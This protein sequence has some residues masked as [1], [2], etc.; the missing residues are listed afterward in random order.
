M[1]LSEWLASISTNEWT[2]FIKRLSANDTGATKSHQVGVYI[3]E[4]V[5]RAVF[6]KLNNTAERN[7][8]HIFISKVES[9]DCKEQEL[10]AIYYNN[11]FFDGTRNEKRIT[12]WNTDTDYN[13]VQD[14]ESTGSLTIFAFHRHEGHNSNYLKVWV[15]R[16][17]TEEDETESQIG[18]ILP[19]T[20]MLNSGDT[21]FSNYQALRAGDYLY[22]IPDEWKT[23]FPSGEEI[24]SYVINNNPHPRLSPDEL[25]VTWRKEEFSI[26]SKIEDIHVQEQIALAMQNGADSATKDAFI[27][28]ANSILNRRKSRSGR[29]LELL[30]GNIFPRFGLAE[31]SAQA[32]TENNKRPDFIFPSIIQYH[33]MD[34]PANRLRMLAVKTTCK[35]RWRQV[36]NE[37]DRL[38][39]NIHLFTLQEGVS[40]NQFNEMREHGVHLVVPKPIHTKYPKDIQNE[41]MSLNGFIESTKKL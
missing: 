34:Y 4:E 26:F 33:N 23:R 41:L 28:L 5:I 18:E 6:P 37:A 14:P 15:C 25:I 10:R 22:G 7:P 40:I 30:L 19:G 38:N 16:N 39:G 13:P 12:R 3:P 29:S 17:P 11:K 20:W 35:D 9:H 2:I 8:D 24:S 32:I 27:A 21:L 36:L 31:F 1:K